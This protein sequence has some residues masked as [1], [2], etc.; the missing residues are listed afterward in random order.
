MITKKYKGVVFGLDYDGTTVSHEY[1]K[2]G[3]DI[4][5]QRVLRR[6]LEAGGLLV[7]NTMRS[8]KEL[9][10]AVKWFSDNDLPLY[11]VGE[12][13]TQK[14]WTSSPKCYAHIYI[15][16]AALGCPLVKCENGERD[17]VD[18]AAVEKLLF[19]D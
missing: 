2:V 6:I 5:A 19:N 7:L 15:D 11:G 12:N 8:G 17:Y 1:P 18:W 10:D 9:A 3:K 13:P 16:D 14:Q 4:G